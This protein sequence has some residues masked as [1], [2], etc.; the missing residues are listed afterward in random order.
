M[1]L[2]IKVHPFAAAHNR[3]H[4]SA[5]YA[6][7]AC[8]ARFNRKHWAAIGA[9]HFCNLKCKGVFQSRAHKEMTHVEE[10]PQ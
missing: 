9:H 3:A 1:R 6:C 7:D 10:S 8:G 4:N 5:L 2:K